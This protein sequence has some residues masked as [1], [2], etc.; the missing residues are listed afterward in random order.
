MVSWRWWAPHATNLLPATTAMTI[1]AGATFDLGGVSQQ[2]ASLSGPAGGIVTSSLSGVPVGLTL[3]PPNA[4]SPNFGGVIQNGNGTLSLVING[5]GTGTQILSGLNTY[6][7]TTAVNAGTL[8]INTVN[9]GATAQALGEGSTVTLGVAGTS[10]GTLQYTG[11]GG[12]LDKQIS[13]L[14]NGSDTISN[15]GGGT[16]TL[17]GGLVK[18]GTTLT[19]SGGKFNITTVGISGSLAHSDMNYTGGSTTTLSVASSYNGP[20]SISGNSTLITAVAGALPTNNAPTYTVL[21][22]GAATDTG[23][24][25]NT[26]DLDG[27]TQIIGGLV[28]GGG[29]A[30]NQV[31]NSNGVSPYTTANGTAGNLTI[32]QLSGVSSTFSGS[33]GGAAAPPTSA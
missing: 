2:V 30:I 24:Q 11:P 31:V 15:T 6:T 27:T 5:S 23:G 17:S 22:L 32:S 9:T 26:L 25:T 18:N 7:G 16:L 19:L 28:S 21:T 13:A 20:T 4:T 3:A 10:S 33:L 1:A 14:G 29:S 12:T 8:S